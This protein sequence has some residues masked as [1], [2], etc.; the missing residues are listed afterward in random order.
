MPNF[1]QFMWAA[2]DCHLWDHSKVELKN[3]SCC[4]LLFVF[5]DIILNVFLLECTQIIC[6]TLVDVLTKKKVKFTKR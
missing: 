2:R 5:I 1:P 4:G 6:P 3:D